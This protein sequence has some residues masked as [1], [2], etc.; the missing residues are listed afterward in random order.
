VTKK[1]WFSSLCFVLLSLYICGESVSLGFGSFGKPGPGFFPFLAGLV[2][3][4]LGIIVFFKAWVSKTFHEKIQ[5]G[6][7]PWK[8]LLLT[9]GSLLGF[10]LLL[11]TLGFNMTTFLFMAILLRAVERKGW[12]LSIGVSL[13]VALG[14][15]IVFEIG[16]QSQLPT[17]PFGFFGF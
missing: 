11:K 2:L 13:S 12:A 7:I 15:Y 16:L 10:N 17:G 1:D 9:F 14:A 8:P 5:G 6:K 3:G 4:S